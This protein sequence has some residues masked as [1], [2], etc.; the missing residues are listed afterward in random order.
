MGKRNQKTPKPNKKS[1]LQ[2]TPIRA[3]VVALGFVAVVA[4]GLW[5]LLQLKERL[6]KEPAKQAESTEEMRISSAELSRAIE[7]VDGYILDA[8][9]QLGVSSKNVARKEI[10]RRDAG[11]VKWNLTDTR[12]TLPEGVDEGRVRAALSKSF[13]RGNVKIRFKP[14]ATHLISEIRTM[15]LPTHRLRFDYR[16]QKPQ[17]AESEPKQNPA[18]KKKSDTPPKEIAKVEIDKS[19]VRETEKALFGDSPKVAIIVD[20]LGADKRAVDRLGAIPAEITFAVLPNLSYSR[21]A[22]EVAHGK[23][24][25]VIL[26][27]PMEPKESTGY[28][29]ADAG[30][31]SALLTGLGKGEILRKLDANLASIPHLKGVNN[32]MGSK[33]TEN[34]E[35]MELVLERI[36]S[37]GLFFVDSKTSPDSA[38]YKTAK[39][40][41]MKAAERD[42]FLD[43]RRDVEYI[44][45]QIEALVKQSKRKGYAVGICHP[46][47]ETIEALAEMIPKIAGEVE[48]IP[49][50]KMVK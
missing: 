40:L 34:E 12:I 32:H 25:D 33:F 29:G 17:P 13:S 6:G 43:N 26:H 4:L 50:S 46:Y 18:L 47:P 39:R 9:F 7:D 15:N 36:K 27:L 16:P 19:P 37:E 8:F 1:R 48:I 3:F 2:P 5:G 22:A 14:A 45:S 21:Y 31:D 24:R 30:G 23:G 38:G 44:K 42:V 41:G 11:G 20:D 10:L 35:L 28:T 49:I